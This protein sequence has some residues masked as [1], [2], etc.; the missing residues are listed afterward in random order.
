MSVKQ[1]V[2]LLSECDVAGGA[3]AYLLGDM[4]KTTMPRVGQS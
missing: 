1:R 3:V 4:L 2:G